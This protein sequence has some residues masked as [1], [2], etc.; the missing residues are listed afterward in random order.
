V[1]TNNFT[2]WFIFNSH[3]LFNLNSRQDIRVTFVQNADNRA[4][5]EFTAGIS[6]GTVIPSVMVDSYLGKHGQVLNLGLAQLRAV[7]GNQNHLGLALAQS[8]DGS[9][10]PQKNL[11]GLHNKLETTVDRVLLLFLCSWV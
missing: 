9:L 8:L 2:K 4:I 7:G 5:V 1:V 10:C 6:Q 11:S 3:L